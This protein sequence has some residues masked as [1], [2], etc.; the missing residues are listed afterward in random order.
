MARVLAQAT[1]EKALDGK[2]F[3]VH[4]W[5]QPPYDEKRDYVIVAADEKTAAFEGIRRFEAEMD[6][7]E[8]APCP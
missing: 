5:G 6:A 8:N 4:T 7:K 3:Y 1:V 2:S